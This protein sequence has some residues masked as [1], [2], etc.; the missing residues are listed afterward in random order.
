MVMQA[1]DLRNLNHL[2]EAHLLDR[3][4]HQILLPKGFR[5]SGTDSP[6]LENNQIEI[7]G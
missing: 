1:A 3:H 2:P 7:I 5:F 6:F 4:S